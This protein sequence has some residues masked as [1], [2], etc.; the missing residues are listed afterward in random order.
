VVLMSL[1]AAKGLEAKFVFMPTCNDRVLPHA[2]SEDLEEE[3]RLAY[4]GVT[5]ARDELE[6]SYVT[7][8]GGRSLRPSPFIPK[9]LL[10]REERRR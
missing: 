8:S 1:H 3:K 2:R 5:R 9:D 6:I 7:S 10:E 4:T